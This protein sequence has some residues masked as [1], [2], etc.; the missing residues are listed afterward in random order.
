[1]TTSASGNSK[2][3]NDGD[4]NDDD[5]DDDGDNDGD[6]SNSGILIFNNSNKTLTPVI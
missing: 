4:D 2:Y 1:M 6:S 5:G 3:S